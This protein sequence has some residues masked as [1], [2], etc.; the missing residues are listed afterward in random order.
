MYPK[1]V[2]TRCDEDDDMTQR[3][4]APE[5]AKYL[6]VSKEIVDELREISSVLSTED[7]VVYVND[8]LVDAYARGY[9]AGFGDAMGRT[10]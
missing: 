4:W 8:I 5:K 10:K 9:E 2:Y 3:E 6:Q 1:R 7:A